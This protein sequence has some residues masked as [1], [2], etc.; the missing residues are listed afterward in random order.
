MHSFVHLNLSVSLCLG[1]TVFIAGIDTAVVNEV[2]FIH[3]VYNI[4]L[5]FE[6]WLYDIYTTF[7]VHG[8]IS[9]CTKRLF[10]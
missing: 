3:A 6:K 5:V 9:W 7:H 2:M 8:R 4:V 1:Y 10:E